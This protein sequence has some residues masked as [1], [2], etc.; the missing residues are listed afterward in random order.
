MA[1]ATMRRVSRP[2]QPPDDGQARRL[3]RAMEKHEAADREYYRLLAE[4]KAEGVSWAE[5]AKVTGHST[6]TLQG[7]VRK[8]RDG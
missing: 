4:V 8:V 2:S 6:S 5:L 3:R 1:D 7:W